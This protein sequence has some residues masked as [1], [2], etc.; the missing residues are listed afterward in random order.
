MEELL[1]SELNYSESE[2]GLTKKIKNH[3]NFPLLSKNPFWIID[4]RIAAQQQIFMQKIFSSLNAEAQKLSE[5]EIENL[6]KRLPLEVGVCSA[7]M[8]L[9][10]PKNNEIVAAYR[11]YKDHVYFLKV[12][13]DEFVS[14]IF[15][16]TMGY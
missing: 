3:P 12:K 16:P 15:F 1:V 10:N 13:N 5:S 4:R 6:I 8:Q 14:V 11:V 2:L 9:L 7:N